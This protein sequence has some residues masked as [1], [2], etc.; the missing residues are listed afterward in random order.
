MRRA[1]NY[2]PTI[3]R[4]AY[5]GGWQSG[6]VMPVDRAQ[7]ERDAAAGRAAAQAVEPIAHPV[8]PAPERKCYRVI[9][10]FSREGHLCL[11]DIGS[12]SVQE[13]MA[14]QTSE[15]WRAQTLDPNGRIYSDNWREMERR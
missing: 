15:R 10:L 2:R 12:G 6:P 4:G 11:E 3:G 8:V 7:G 13:A 9:R 1:R 14:I 5:A